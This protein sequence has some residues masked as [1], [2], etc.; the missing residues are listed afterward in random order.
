MG[1]KQPCKF[2]NIISEVKEKILYEDEQIVIIEDIKPQS[3]VHLLALPRQHIKNINYLTKD[4]LQLVTHMK[5]QS[6]SYVK[7]EYGEDIETK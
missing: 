7:K 3:K 6:E 1:N 5:N 2:C 4:H